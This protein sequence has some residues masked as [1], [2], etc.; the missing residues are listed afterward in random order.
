MFGV[1]PVLGLP[2]G[3]SDLVR[4]LGVILAGLAAVV[5]ARFVR[6]PAWAGLTVRVWQRL[7]HVAPRV[8]RV[9]LRGLAQGGAKRVRVSRAGQQ[10]GVDAVARVRLPGGRG[11]LVRVLGYEAAG[12]RS[13]LEALLASPEMAAALEAMPEIGRVLRPI[14]RMLGRRWRWRRRWRSARPGRSGRGRR[15][16]RSPS[17]RKGGR[18][19]ISSKSTKAGRALICPFHYDSKTNEVFLLL[20]VHKKKTL[21]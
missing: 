1:T 19:K 20:F 16:A 10:R 7:T 2:E 12:Y 17:R 4:R 18:G 8:G 21:P 3:L 11:W 15:P 6:M 9:M 13:Q 14:C 5:A